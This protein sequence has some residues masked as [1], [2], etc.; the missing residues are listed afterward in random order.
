[1]REGSAGIEQKAAGALP[2][3]WMNGQ[4]TCEKAGRAIQLPMASQR[5]PTQTSIP[6]YTDAQVEAM[7]GQ[8]IKKTP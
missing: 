8:Y 4:T 6:N 2:N 7:F 1:M 3:N 5:I